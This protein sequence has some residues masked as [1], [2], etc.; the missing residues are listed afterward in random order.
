MFS[1]EGKTI[2]VTGASSGIGRATAIMLAE[3]GAHLIITGR[4]SEKLNEVLTVLADDKH[5]ALTYDLNVD[6]DISTLAKGVGQIDGLVHSAGIIDYTLYKNLNREKYD[7]MFNINFYSAIQL[8]NLLL[9]HKKINK[10]ASLVYISSISSIFG[11][12]ATALYASSK[13][14]LNAAVKVLASEL[15]PRRIRANT[16]MP[17]IVRTP[18]IEEAAGMLDSESFELAEKAYPLGLGSPEDV[19]ST[20]LFLLSDASKWMTGVSLLLDGGY[21]LI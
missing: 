21:S 14:A 12:P 2:L 10:A 16:I 6:E 13:A 11:V 5:V 15:A 18:M 1:L 17:G 3:H 7:R 8:T 20:C 9:K 19:A 4:N